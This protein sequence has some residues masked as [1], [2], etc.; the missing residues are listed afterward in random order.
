MTT[1]TD[2]ALELSDAVDSLRFEA[3]VTH[4]YNPL[5]YAR[6]PHLSY[7]HRWGARGPRKAILVGMNP[8][9]WGMAQ[10]GV[11]FGEI[12]FREVGVAF[13]EV[14][15]HGESEHGVAEELETFVRRD[16]A[17]LVGVGAVCQG[18]TKRGGGG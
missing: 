4:T 7:L 1:T 10:T 2:I 5:V 17:L 11:P 14:P 15:G 6:A 9:P 13:I 3:P 16:T 12:A 8:G 18:K